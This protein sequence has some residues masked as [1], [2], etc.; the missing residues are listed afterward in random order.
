MPATTDYLTNPEKLTQLAQLLGVEEAALRGIITQEYEHQAG[1]PLMY[2]ADG[3]TKGG[4]LL[5]SLDQAKEM[6]I[7][8]EARTNSSSHL[9]HTIQHVQAHLALLVGHFEELL[10]GS[11]APA[12]D[13]GHG[14]LLRWRELLAIGPTLYPHQLD[15]PVLAI[16]TDHYGDTTAFPLKLEH[17]PAADGERALYT[18][19]AHEDYQVLDVEKADEEG[20]LFLRPLPAGVPHLAFNYTDED[21]DERD[22]R[23]SAPPM[24]AKPAPLFEPGP[25]PLFDNQ[26]ENGPNPAP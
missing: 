17:N 26:P 19:E 7:E 5:A 15:E 2:V 20:L 14:E 21:G 13:T 25:A 22:A 24:S 9:S 23:L 12:V 3:P 16:I 8:L 1:Y 4:L 10:R 18:N 6:A 11:L